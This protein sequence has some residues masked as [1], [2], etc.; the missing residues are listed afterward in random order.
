MK[1]ITTG[2]M[3]NLAAFCKSLIFFVWIYFCCWQMFTENKSRKKNVPGYMYLSSFYDVW[4]FPKFVKNW[5]FP[6]LWQNLPLLIYNKTRSEIQDGQHCGHFEFLFWNNLIG[7][8]CHTFCSKWSIMDPQ[9]QV[10]PQW[11]CWVNVW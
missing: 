1:Y 5:T 3:W 11:G 6:E 4:S 8:K 7:W 9:V 2:K 10:K